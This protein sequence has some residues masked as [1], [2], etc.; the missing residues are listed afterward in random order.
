MLR[1]EMNGVIFMRKMI[2][3]K[4]SF[5]IEYRVTDKERKM[6]Y[7]R[8]WLGGNFL[9]T[10]QDLIYFES[11]LLS[12]LEYIGKIRNLKLTSNPKENY[13]I[14]EKKVNDDDDYDIYQYQ[15]SFVTLTDD[16]LI[17]SYH[18][19]GLIHIH[20][21]LMTSKKKITFDD[22]KPYPRRSLHHAIAYDDFW[23]VVN[24]LSDQLS[25]LQNL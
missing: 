8:I 5:G 24:T 19:E 6:G 7:A 11:Y 14:L 2:G 12:G 10:F 15:I 21:K 4:K 17:F 20:W 22:L 1:N 23:D 9:G 13:R 16:F 18:T 25:K 3:S